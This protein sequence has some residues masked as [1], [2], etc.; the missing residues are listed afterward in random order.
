MVIKG[1]SYANNT[2]P[3]LLKH[4]NSG[5]ANFIYLYGN[6]GYVSCTH[7]PPLL[8]HLNGG[9]ANFFYMYGNNGYI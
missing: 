1:T 7:S 3:P 5:I 9:I 6:K 2:P 4:L 8:K